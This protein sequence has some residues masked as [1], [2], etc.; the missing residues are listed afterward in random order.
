MKTSVILAALAV[1]STAF[2]SPADWDRYGEKG[3]KKG[4]DGWSG[5]KFTSTYNAVATPGQVIDTN[6]VCREGHRKWPA[7]QLTCSLPK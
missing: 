3:G 6:D 1:V 2:A 4:G 5:K 7:S